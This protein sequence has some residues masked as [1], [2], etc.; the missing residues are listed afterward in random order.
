[1]KKLLGKLKAGAKAVGN[2]AA[3]LI[4]QFLYQGPR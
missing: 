1:M 3:E 4:G 2:A